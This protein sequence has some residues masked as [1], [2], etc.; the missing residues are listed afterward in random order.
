M[1][2]KKVCRSCREKIKDSWDFCPYCGRRI[3]KTRD[4]FFGDIDREFE[5]MDKLFED[6]KPSVFRIKPVI[7]GTGITI[8]VHTGRDMEPKINVR[9]L[10]GHRKIEPQMNRL[11]VGPAGSESARSGHLAEEPK[12]EIKRSGNRQSVIIHL[13]DVKDERDVEIKILEQS[14][15]VRAYSKDK[16]Y[17]KLIPIQ[18]ASYVNKEFR[19]GI[20]RLDIEK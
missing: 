16:S 13:P 10:G 17:F 7:K 4:G 5:R 18:R 2:E 8:T 15:E 1:F 19:N 14:I 3:S 11:A 12:T 9:R 6:S 20:L